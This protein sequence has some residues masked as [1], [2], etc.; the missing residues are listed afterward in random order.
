[1]E[2]MLDINLFKFSKV[3]FADTLSFGKQKA[4]TMYQLQIFWRF[5]IQFL[6]LSERVFDQDNMNDCHSGGWSIF[7]RFSHCQSRAQS[8]T[9]FKMCIPPVHL[10]STMRQRQFSGKCLFSMFLAAAM[11]QLLLQILFEF[12]Q[13]LSIVVKH[14]RLALKLYGLPMVLDQ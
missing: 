5:G 13:I 6:M 12:N 1:M 4:L 8:R 11:P 14:Y 9:E 10:F 3:I 2:K 7:T